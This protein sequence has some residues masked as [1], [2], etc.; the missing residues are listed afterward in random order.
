MPF[1]QLGNLVHRY[2]V[3][4]PEKAPAIVFSN[5]LGTDL[6][7]WDA[8]VARLCD[9]FRTVQS[10]KRGHGLTDI[11][12]RPCAIND[13]VEDLVALLNVL[14]IG[15]TVI[16]GVSIG[17]MIA[18]AFTAAHPDRVKAL[19]LCDTGMRIGPQSM[20]DERI[21]TIRK[22]GLAGIAATTM[23]RWFTQAFRDT[24]TAD[25][26]G[27]TNMLLRT[28]VE[29]YTAACYALR[30]ADLSESARSIRKPTLVVCG[31]QD[32]ATP[33]DLG[34]SLAAAIPAARFSLIK[35]AAHLPCVEQPDALSHMIVQFLKENAIG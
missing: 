33:P 5:S 26:K 14:A 16:C 27:Y 7:I 34:R 35:N 25:L 30:D 6:R 20:W 17:G 23:G 18:Q 15:D 4:G 31:D 8:V 1:V 2:V 19:I 32:V 9:R 11:P 3:E 28:P 12:S 10:D 22:S 24:S 29:G 13:Y 21:A